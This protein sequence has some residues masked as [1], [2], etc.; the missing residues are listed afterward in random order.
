MITQHGNQHPMCIASLHN[1]ASSGIE[2][3]TTKQHTFD[4]ETHRQTDGK[5]EYQRG[6]HHMGIYSVTLLHL[7]T[8]DTSL[9]AAVVIKAL[10]F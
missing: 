5:I 3:T 4:E 6:L 2:D 8:T 7:L 1:A 10:C 9:L